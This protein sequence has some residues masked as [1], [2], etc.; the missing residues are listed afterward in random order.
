[1]KP[2]PVFEITYA[3]YIDQI[4]KIDFASI[5][6]KI[7]AQVEGDEILIPVLGNLCRVSKNGILDQ[8]GKRPS[9]DVCVILCKYLILCPKDAPEDKEWV[10][11]RDLKDSGPLTVAFKNNVE[12]AIAAHFAGKKEALEKAGQQ[13]GGYSPDMELSYDLVMA[14][15]ILPKLPLLLLYNDADEEFPA[16]CS[17]LLERCSEKYLDAECLA[18]TGGFLFNSLKRAFTYEKE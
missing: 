5:A 10:S 7:G 9:F 12:G 6:P 18:M 3:N 16:E 1:M 8:T 4:A 2:S 17:V 11:F 15:D 13:I 14:F